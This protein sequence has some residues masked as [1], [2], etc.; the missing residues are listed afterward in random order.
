MEDLE[1]PLTFVLAEMEM[2][3]VS[4]DT[5]RLEDMKV[6]LGGRLKTLEA[7]IHSLAGEE[8]NINSPKQLGVILFEK[9]ELPQSRKQKQAIQQL[10]M[11]WK[12]CL[13]NTR[14]LMKFC[15]IVNLVKFS[16]LISKGCLK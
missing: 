8:F 15:Y 3:G 12:V 2:Q 11:Y 16:P 4:V 7:S 1:L 13:E 14:L 9:L 6:E 10:R 5:D